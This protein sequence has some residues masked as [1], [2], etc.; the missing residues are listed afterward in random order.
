MIAP[1][2]DDPPTRPSPGRIMGLDPGRKRIGVALSDEWRLIASPLTV[3]VRPSGPTGAEAAVEAV[4]RLV[5]EHGV[6][7]VVCGLPKNMDG[8]LGLAGRAVMDFAQRLQDRLDCPVTFIDERLTSAQAE[9]VLLEADVS[10]AKRRGAVDKMAAALIL[11]G[12]LDADK[13]SSSPGDPSS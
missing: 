7:E 9:R 8:S 5:A 1:A 10:R 11:Q 12:R 2:A 13:N 3:I 4:A 6:V